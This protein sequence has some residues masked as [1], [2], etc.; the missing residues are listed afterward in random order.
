MKKQI[1]VTPEVTVVHMTSCE[2]L[3][4]GSANVG[5]WSDDGYGVNVNGNSSPR[6]QSH[7][8]RLIYGAGRL[9]C[10]RHK[11]Y[12]RSGITSP[13]NCTYFLLIPVLPVNGKL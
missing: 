9:F 2:H 13:R 8:E 1:Y 7:L 5:G 11:L 4:A 10:P 12:P 3:L 6:I